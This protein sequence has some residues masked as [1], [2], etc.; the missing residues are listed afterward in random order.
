MVFL[1][2]G[3]FEPSVSNAPFPVRVLP[4]DVQR[5]VAQDGAGLGAL[6]P[7]YPSLIAR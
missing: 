4:E 1:A 5:D 3:R 6:R 2:K 7:W